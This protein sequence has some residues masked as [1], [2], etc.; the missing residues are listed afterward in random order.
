[1]PS[2][3]RRLPARFRRRTGRSRWRK[4]VDLGLA[5]LVL[6]LVALVAAHLQ[7]NVSIDAEGTPRVGDGDS[8]TIGGER[9]RLVGIDA[10]EL[11]QSCLREGTEYACGERAREALVDLVAGRT[12]VCEARERDRYGRLLATC[13]AGDTN[14]NRA[15][16]EAGWAVA[17][18]D[19]GR[20]EAL[21]K[22]AGRGL[23]AGSFDPPSQWRRMHGGL[24][25]DFDGLLSRLSQIIRR[26]LGMD[27]N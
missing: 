24:V 6:A 12:V 9:I 23:W 11:R 16:V 22:E 17:Y 25:E 5:L 19:Y 20:E 18:G 2:R 21:A 3:S 8:L 13:R 15:M 27:G 10:P 14:L 4:A 7:P 1:M 26:L